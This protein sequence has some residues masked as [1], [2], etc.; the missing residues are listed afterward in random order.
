MRGALNRSWAFLHA[1]VIRELVGMGYGLLSE[2]PVSAA[3]FLSG[4]LRQPGAATLRGPP[5]GAPVSLL[6]ESAF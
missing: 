4:P 1:G 2:L 5:G 3:P 6:N